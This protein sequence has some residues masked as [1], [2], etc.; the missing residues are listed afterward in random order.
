MFPLDSVEG[1]PE[2]TKIVVRLAA[3]ALALTA[4]ATLF[5]RCDDD[6]IQLSPNVQRTANVEYGQG[7]VRRGDPQLRPLF[8]DILAPTD[9]PE[10]PKPGLLLIHGG[11]FTG[12]SRRDPELIRFADALASRGYVCFLSDYRLAGEDPPAPPP[13]DDVPVERAAHAAIV[14]AKAALR[15]IAANAAQYNVDVER[16]A[17]LGESAGATA[18]LAAG[19]A[20]EGAF[21]QDAP[22]LPVPEANHPSTS[23]RPAAVIEFWG[24]ADQILDQ[25]TAGDPPLMI[26]HGTADTN[27]GTS[28]QEAKAIVDRCVEVGLQYEFHP[29]QGADHGAW[30]ARVNGKG[31]PELTASFLAAHMPP[32]TH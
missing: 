23:I 7:Y 13:F 25:I 28:F 1:A 15:F 6:A 18:A 32:D 27:P 26:A 16:I 8:L 5:S 21:V 4:A 22:A 19:M 2:L 17:V 31:L 12:G 30:N 20:P 14:D 9:A 11:N 29:L 3:A 24:S 10:G